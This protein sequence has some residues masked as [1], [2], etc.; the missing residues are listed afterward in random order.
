LNTVEAALAVG[1]TRYVLASSS[2]VYNE[3][4]QVPTPETERLVI[5]DPQ[6][7]RF[8][9]AGGKIASELLALHLGQ[10]RGLH[11]VIFRPHNVYGPDMGFEHFIPEVVERIVHL[12]HGFQARTIDLPIQGSGDETRSFCYISDAARGAFLAGERGASGEVYNVGTQ[13]EVRVRWV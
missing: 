4:S 2:E 12:S 10:R 9:Y 13:R 3:P 7:P 5:A 11:V 8:S 6:N 1:A